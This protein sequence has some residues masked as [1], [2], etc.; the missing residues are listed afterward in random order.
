M[1][2]LAA[3]FCTACRRFIC[4]GAVDPTEGY[5]S[6]QALTKSDVCVCACSFVGDVWTDLTQRSDVEKTRSDNG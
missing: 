2:V 4:F 6:S 3:A 5:C 1:T